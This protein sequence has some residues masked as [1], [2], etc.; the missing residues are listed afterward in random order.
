[1]LHTVDPDSQRF[2]AEIDAVVRRWTEGDDREYLRRWKQLGNWSLNKTQGDVVKKAALKKALFARSK[3][4]CEDCDG[5]FAPAALHMHRLD[6]SHSQDR[7]RNF[8][9]FDGNIAL[10]CAGCHE[11]REASL[12]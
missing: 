2:Q 11:R 7:S 1:M 12:R 6:T 10:L 5:E 9:Y 3:G 4:R 8:G